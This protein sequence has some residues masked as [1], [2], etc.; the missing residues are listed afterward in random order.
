[1]M[2]NKLTWKNNYCMFYFICGNFY[3]NVPD[4]K[5]F[6]YQ[7]KLL[8]CFGTEIL[9]SPSFEIHIFLWL[10]FLMDCLKTP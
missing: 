4:F 7:V 9:K 10:T 5:E 6:M 1:M 8:A 3:E 2:Q